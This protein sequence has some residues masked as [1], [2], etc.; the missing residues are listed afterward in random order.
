MNSF[1]TAVS[2]AVIAVLVYSTNASPCTDTCSGQC[3]FAQQACDLT[4]LLGGLCQTQA[5][6][7]NTAC[8][9]VCNCVDTC[10][11]QCGGQLAECRGDGT[12]P[13]SMITCGFAFTSCNAMCNTQCA[14]TTVAGVVDTIAGSVASK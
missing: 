14:F 10:G 12:N 7:C 4:G 9:A 13:L 11:A 3:G 2:L 8:G 1:R 6:I 5:T